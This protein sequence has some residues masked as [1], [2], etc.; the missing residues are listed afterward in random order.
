MQPSLN[1]NA[2]VTLPFGQYRLGQR[3]RPANDDAPDAANDDER[4]GAAASEKPMSG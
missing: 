3:P 1:P 2:D 4:G